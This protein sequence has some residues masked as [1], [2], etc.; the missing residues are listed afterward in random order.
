VATKLQLCLRAQSSV[1]TKLQSAAA[2]RSEQ[3]SGSSFLAAPSVRFPYT[4]RITLVSPHPRATIA[5]ANTANPHQLNTAQTLPAS[6]STGG[7]PKTSTNTSCFPAPWFRT[8]RL[9]NTNLRRIKPK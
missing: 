5:T 8:S 9:A 2:D 6:Q 3:P 4:L 7:N 1:A